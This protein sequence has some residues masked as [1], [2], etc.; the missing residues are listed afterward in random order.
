MFSRREKVPARVR[1]KASRPMSTVREDGLAIGEHGVEFDGER[2][3]RRVVRRER[4]LELREEGSEGAR[5]AVPELVRVVWDGKYGI[6][7]QGVGADE[8]GVDAVGLV[9]ERS[10]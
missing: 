6:V 2:V 8:S 9:R 3:E 1:S 4:D 7:R 10:R 5:F